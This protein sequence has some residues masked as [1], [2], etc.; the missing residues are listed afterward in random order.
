MGEWGRRGAAIGRTCLRR[1][2]TKGI[3][4]RTQKSP[5]LRKRGGIE[6]KPRVWVG[7]IGGLGEGDL[8]VY[9]EEEKAQGE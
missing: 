1:K 7:E 4:D 2:G 6:S 5:C 9:E 3:S 8:Y